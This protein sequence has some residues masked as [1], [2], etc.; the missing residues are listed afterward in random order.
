MNKEIKEM[1]KFACVVCEMCGTDEKGGFRCG[2]GA[3]QDVCVLCQE[4]GEAL[5]NTGYHKTKVKTNRDKIRSMADKEL[6]D[7]CIAGS[8]D[9]YADEPCYISTMT[10]GVY[11]TYEE[12]YQS[13]LEWLK[14][15]HKGE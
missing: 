2:A 3:N 4:L 11:W 12:A 13:N 9:D 10:H 15:E 6:A 1:G 5:Y 8:W 14:K 7:L